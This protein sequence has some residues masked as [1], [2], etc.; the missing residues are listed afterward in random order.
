MGVVP[1]RVPIG[2]PDVTE[3]K[4]DRFA[5]SLFDTVTALLVCLN[6]TTC[7]VTSGVKPRNEWKRVWGKCDQGGVQVWKEAGS[8]ER[9]LGKKYHCSMRTYNLITKKN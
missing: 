4:G 7:A 5:E 9:F 3:D 1:N 6:H 2:G 8:F